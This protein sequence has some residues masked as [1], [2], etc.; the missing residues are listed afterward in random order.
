MQLKQ[1]SIALLCGML[2]TGSSMAAVSPEEAAKLGNEL[3]PRGAEAAANADGTIPAWSNEPFTPPASFKAGDSRRPDPWPDEK[4]YLV[5]TKANMGE[6]ADKLN[7][8]AKALLQKYGDD[9][10][11]MNIYPT[12]RSMAAPQWV[13]DNV[14]Y[15]ATHTKLAAEGLKIEDFQSG[16]PFP[17]PQSGVELVWNHITRWIATHY[18]S[19]Y[20]TY[21]I[22]KAGKPVLAATAMINSEPAFYNPDKEYAVKNAASMV[23]IDYSAPAR[24]AGEKLLVIDPTDFTSGGGRKSWQ[25]LKGQRR[26]RQAPTVAFD[27]PNPGAAGIATFDDAFLFNGSP[28]RYDWKLV[29][30]REMY[31]PYN[32]NELV[33]YT[34]SKDA[35][36]PKFVKPEVTRWELHR[37]WVV[38]ATLK[39]GERHIYERR[40]FY[41]DEDSWMAAASEAYDVS[42][43]LW[44]VGFSYPASLYDVPAATIG[45]YGHYDLLSGIYY[46]AGLTGQYYG[47]KTSV[48]QKSSKFYTSQGLSKSGIR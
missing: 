14:A 28:E 38:E 11:V 42:G 15:N 2:L 8:G 19:Q 33:F 30:K 25:Y 44:R 21:Y 16:T 26:V 5:I 47:I 7:D 10:F 22:D 35:L 41:F 29:G 39:D 1:K 3:T 40:V 6:H 9:G 17:I 4:P 31:I 24:R 12:H 20:D 36:S 46:V 34:K 13:Y 23:R 43:A 18:E 27:T 48:E 32:S 45:A 37:V